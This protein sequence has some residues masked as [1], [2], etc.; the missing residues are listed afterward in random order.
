L[1]GYHFTHNPPW[2][3]L[4]LSWRDLTTWV[5]PIVNVPNSP[6]RRKWVE[7]MRRLYG[8]IDRYKLV[9]LP[10][11]NWEE[12]LT[13]DRPMHGVSSFPTVRQDQIAF[14]REVG[15]EWYRVWH[16]SIRRYDPNHII[17]GDRNSIHFT[18]L[19]TYILDVMYPYVDA[20]CVNMMGTAEQMMRNLREILMYWD[21]PIFPA[22]TGLRAWDGRTEKSGG[23]VASFEAVGEGYWD[24]L[25][26]GAAHPQIIGIAWCSYWETTVH[27]SGVRDAATGEV[28]RAI[29][30]RMRAANQ[31]VQA[32]IRKTV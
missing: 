15:K 2:S 11:R 1:I 13:V 30:D 16:E 32:E 6:A 3:Y 31:W 19:P 17:F 24:H 26:L 28:N 10:L 25:R 9:Y 23:K 22:D 8:T 12:L 21:K 5:N 4:N 20:L 14:I 18:L 27:H 29:V 7:L